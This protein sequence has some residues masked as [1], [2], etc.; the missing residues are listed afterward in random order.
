MAGNTAATV[1]R[2]DDTRYTL[3]VLQVSG[4]VSVTVGAGKFADAANNFNV[5]SASQSYA[6]PSSNVPA[7]YSLVW[8]DEFSCGGPA[9]PRQVGLRHR[10]QQAR[11]VQ[12][13]AAVLRHGPA[14]NSSVAD[15]KL[16]DHRAPEAAVH[17]A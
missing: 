16:I 8:S 3:S 11:L 2:L 13:R 17:R 7:G 6:D 5:A 10:P 12:Q 9:R 15:G 14:E 1:T 4:T